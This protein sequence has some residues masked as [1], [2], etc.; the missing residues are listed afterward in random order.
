MPPL[1]RNPAGKCATCNH[2]ESTEINRLIAAGTT[3]KVISQQYGMD[4]ASVSRHVKA[5]IPRLLV[6][7]RVARDIGG[8]IVVERQLEKTFAHINKLVDACDEWLLD[9]DGTGK[10]TLEPRSREINVVYD[11]YNDRDDK[12]KPKRKKANLQELIGRLGE[13]GYEVDLLQ[14][15]SADPRELVL[16]SAAEIRAHLDFYAK[17][18]GLYQKERSNEI[19][20]EERKRFVDDTIGGIM[21]KF[22]VDEKSARSW[23]RERFPDIPEFSDY[24]M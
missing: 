9:P 11:D 23:A 20:R 22:G 24:Q 3:Y 15:K 10:Y 14:S 6:S 4:Q 5:C 7:T 17:L 21:T 19:E 8:G 1:P 12:G 13:A 18:H 16:Q 2:A